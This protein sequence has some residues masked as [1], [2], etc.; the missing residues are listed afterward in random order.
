MEIL[1]LPPTIEG[2]ILDMDG[3]LYP[4][5]PQEGKPYLDES[6]EGEWQFIAQNLGLSV[7]DA[8][9]AVQAKKGEI[10]RRTGRVTSLTC[11][12][13]ELGIEKQAWDRIRAECYFPERHLKPNPRLRA[14]L[15][16]VPADVRVLIFS[17]SPRKVAERVVRTIGIHDLGIRVLGVDEV[18]TF[19]P[20]PAAFDKAARIAGVPMEALVS[21]GDRRDIDCL[22]PLEVG[23]GGAVHVSGPEDVIEF[24]TTRVGCNT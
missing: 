18:T 22:V 5:S 6:A 12:L 17:N 24:L 7:S 15:A 4:Y 16:Q 20:D 3:T 9:G 10:E 14:A 2:L 8:K 19:K 1:R 21:V 11:T 13:V 23:Y